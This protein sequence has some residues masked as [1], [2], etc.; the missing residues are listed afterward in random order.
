MDDLR[1]VFSKET[2]T[3]E[4]CEKPYETL[5]IATKED[6]EWLQAAAE[7]YSNRNRYAEVTRCK[8]CEYCFTHITKRNNQKIWVCMR[9][10]VNAIVRPDDFCSRAKKN[11]KNK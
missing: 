7:F 11:T 8:N 6:F 10:N 2:G 1:I 5:N 4:K 3:W 9:G